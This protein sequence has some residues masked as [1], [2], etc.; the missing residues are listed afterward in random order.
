MCENA[1]VLWIKIEDC[2]RYYD[3]I[4]MIRHLRKKLEKSQLPRSL[5]YL[6]YEELEEL[7]RIMDG[8]E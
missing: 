5:R 6:M 8:D 3:Q 4:K 2:Y 1:L 7:F